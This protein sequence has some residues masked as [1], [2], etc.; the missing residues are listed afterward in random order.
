[1]HIRRGAPSVLYLLLGVCANLPAQSLLP[2]A[3]PVPHVQAVPQPYGQV[4][5]ERDGQETARFHFGPGLNR[6]FVFPIIGPSGRTLTR[7]GHPG[8][9]YGHSHHNSVWISLIDVNGIDFWSDHSPNQGRI[10]HDRVVKLDDGDDAASVETISHWIAHTGEV[11]LN[12]RRVTRVETLPDKEWILTIDLQLEPASADVRLKQQKQFGP[13]G[14]RVAKTISAQYG[15]GLLRN[16]EG[17]TGEK[18]MFRKRAKWV[19]YSGPVMPGVIEGLTL[20]DHPANPSHPSHFHVR[21]DGWMGALITEAG[22]VVLTRGKPLHLR[23]GIYVHSGM[24]PAARIEQRWEQFAK[25][26][27]ALR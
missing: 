13:I 23:Y 11:L 4:S 9:P 18:A 2:D 5:F 19:D 7:M 15:G 21:Q 6:P 20:M 10:V 24:P 22:D 12:E 3:K 14:V 1:M 26:P 27:A 8:D 17:L 16:S 25:E